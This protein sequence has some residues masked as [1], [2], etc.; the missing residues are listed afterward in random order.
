M[1]V[2]DKKK[3]GEKGILK[4]EIFLFMILSKLRPQRGKHLS[5]DRGYQQYLGM[6]PPSCVLER[7]SLYGMHSL[8]KQGVRGMDFEVPCSSDII[9]LG[10]WHYRFYACC[11]QQWT[12]IWESVTRSNL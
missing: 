2:A 9:V 4:A 8:G 6:N 5:V 3:F 1:E 7:T 12:G 10:P 11:F